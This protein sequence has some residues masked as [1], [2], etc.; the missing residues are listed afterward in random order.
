MNVNVMLSTETGNH[1]RNRRDGRMAWMVNCVVHLAPIGEVEQVERG[2]G[3]KRR[4]SEGE[5]ACLGEGIPS[6][7]QSSY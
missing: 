4:S 5:F 7:S 3:Y 1:V 2:F 6:H